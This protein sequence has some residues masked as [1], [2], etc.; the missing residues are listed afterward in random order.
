[1]KPFTTNLYRILPF[2]ILAVGLVITCLVWANS[3]HRETAALREEFNFMANKTLAVIENRLQAN[4]QVLRGV[5][6]LYAACGQVDRRSFRNYVETLHLH[7]RYPGILGVGFSL[8]VPSR[9]KARHEQQFRN[10]GFPDYVISPPG[11]RGLYTAIIYL[12][13]FSGRNLRA[14]G[15]DMYSEP[16]RRAAMSRA[17]D[18][19]EPALSGTVTLVQETTTDVQAGFLIYIPIYRNGAPHATIAER[20][21]SLVGW[22]YSPLRMKD[23]MRNVLSR[24]LPEVGSQVDLHIYDGFNLVPDALMFDSEGEVSPLGPAFEV[25]RQLQIAGHVWTLRVQSLP[26]FDARL[27]SE[28]DTIIMGA[29]VA[30]STLLSLLTWVLVQSREKIALALRQSDQAN[31]DLAQSEDRVRTYSTNLESLVQ[32]RT[33]ELEEANRELELRRGQAEAANRAK[34][35][36]LATMSHELR[37][38]LT[39]II[40]QAEILCEKIHGSL[41]A[42]Q[43][44]A[45]RSV[46]SS[47][48]HLLSLIND[49]LDLSKIEAAMLELY[50]ETV[51]IE[52]L[53]SACLMFVK[54]DAQRKRLTVSMSLDPAV[55]SFRADPRRVKQLLVNLLINGVKFTPDGGA[56]GLEVTGDRERRLL[57]FTVWDTGIGI[58]AEDL[59]QLFK[60][61]VQVDSSLT[62]QYEGTG[63]GLALV[64]QLVRLHG[65]S[66][67]VA[68]EVGK[69]SRFTVTLPWEENETPQNGASL[70]C[71]EVVTEPGI[72]TSLPGAPLILVVDD[73]PA[74]VEMMLGYLRNSDYRV[75][76]VSSGEEA[77]ALTRSCFPSLILM[78]IQMPGMDG[79][80]AIRRIR[81]LPGPASRVPIIA[82]TALAMQGDRERCLAAGADEYLSKPVSMTEL[83][84]RIHNLL[85]SISERKSH[86]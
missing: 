14:F 68:S 28:R 75:T 66:V 83:K 85:V 2:L 25:V 73:S 57:T 64:E 34:S 36:F 31:R 26:G 17:C 19:G 70:P 54:H 27:N 30:L 61:F 86:A 32:L 63:L 49:I 16:V 81:R 18:E 48:R 38:P 43:Q 12:E 67:S 22:A 20:Q 35:M 69:G 71:G 53:C 13:P 4:V 76:A 79:L 29:G 1:M 44:K 33:H 24:Q 55:S 10:E 77:V 39:V 8:V 50:H 41:N 52:A 59:E 11:D 21:N 51:S 6:G 46:E 82:L 42:T 84:I 9:E 60:P 62:R 78:D 72:E 37:T 7:E 40:G 47:G 58:A 23:L 74:T 65:G 80:E 3:R 15:Y 56:V 45:V 5:A